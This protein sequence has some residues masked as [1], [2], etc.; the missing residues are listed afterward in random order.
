MQKSHLLAAATSAALFALAACNSEP[1]VVTINKYDP[2]AEALKNAAPIAP[3]PM[4]QVSRTYRCRDNSLVF[5]DF[6]TNDT[7]AVR[8]ER[9][10]PPVATLTAEGG[11][12]PY[13]ADGYSVSGSGEEVTY[14]APGKGSQ[15]CRA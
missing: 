15:T 7:A 5:I 14:S 4:I 2:Q 1:E 12:P 8:T 9:R 10:T 6:Y 3:P 13:T 11:N